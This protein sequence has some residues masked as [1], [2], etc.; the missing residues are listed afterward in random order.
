[1]FTGESDNWSVRY[2]VEKTNS[3][4]PTAGAIQYIGKETIP[5]RIEYSYDKASGDEPLNEYGV[6]T[7]AKG[8]TYAREDSEI[9]VML[10]WDNQTETIPLTVKWAVS[11]E[12]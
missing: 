11:F 12:Q 6:A 7:L 1:M 9:A 5:K 4:Q 3:C 10:K 8:C 2:E